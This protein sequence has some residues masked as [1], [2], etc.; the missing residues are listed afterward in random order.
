MLSRPHL[1]VLLAALT[2]SLFATTAAEAAITFYDTQ[3]AFDAAFPGDTHI[4]FTSLTPAT[5]TSQVL[6]GG[7]VVVGGDTIFADHTLLALA[8]SD[9]GPGPYGDYKTT[10]LSAQSIGDELDQITIETPGATALGFDYG[11]YADFPDFTLTVTLS[12]GE[13][14]TPPEPSDTAQ[15]IGFSSGGTPITSVKISGVYAQGQLGGSVID[16]IDISQAGVTVPPPVPEPAEWALMLL[17]FGLIG[18]TLRR[19]QTAARPAFAAHI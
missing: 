19:R 6:P 10:F 7:K 4:D 8:D 1:S 11:S 13:S 18:A 3:A 16:L 14:F 15:F 9:P 5:G 17:G 12:T 2:S